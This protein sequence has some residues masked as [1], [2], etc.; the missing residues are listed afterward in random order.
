MATKET[1]NKTSKGGNS[2]I[3][4][5]ANERLMADTAVRRL[6]KA[7]EELKVLL[8]AKRENGITQDL[9]DKLK[10]YPT[11]K[12]YADEVRNKAR[13]GFGLDKDETSNLTCELLN[14]ITIIEDNNE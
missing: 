10:E 2:S 11:Y 14:E 13:K 3:W 4:K 6:I 8:E 7:E 5:L 9:I 12:D 1:S